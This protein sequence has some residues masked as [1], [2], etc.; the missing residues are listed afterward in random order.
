MN[1]FNLIAITDLALLDK[2]AVLLNF[3]K[4]LSLDEVHEG[5]KKEHAD[6]EIPAV[7]VI[8]AM[9]DFIQKVPHTLTETTTYYSIVTP[10]DMDYMS[11]HVYSR[12]TRN[13][14]PYPDTWPEVAAFMPC[15]CA[16]ISDSGVRLVRD[17]D[18]T[19]G[20]ALVKQEVTILAPETLN[21]PGLISSGI[22]K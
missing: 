8:R 22:K 16:F 6:S 20:K 19:W 7:S 9:A 2:Y 17:R 3:G 5:F 21:Q 15:H 18:Y 12:K 14:R 10:S 13:R 1:N 4:C 11:T